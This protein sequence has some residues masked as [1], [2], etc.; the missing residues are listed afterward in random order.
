[1]SICR[2]AGRSCDFTEVKLETSAG[3][4]IFTWSLDDDALD[5]P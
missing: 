4:F 3:D 5:I 2:D 1:M